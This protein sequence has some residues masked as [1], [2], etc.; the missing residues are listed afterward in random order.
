MLIRAREG[1]TIEP[2]LAVLRLGSRLPDGKTRLA[3]TGSSRTFVA[4]PKYSGYPPNRSPRRP[5][6]RALL[7]TIGIATALIAGVIALEHFHTQGQRVVAQPP[8]TPMRC[9]PGSIVV[10]ESGTNVISEFGSGSVTCYPAA[11]TGDAVPTQSFFKVMSGPDALAFDS[12]GDL[13]VGN[14]ESNKLVEYP[15]AQL[16]KASPV[17]GT[18]ISSDA[19]DSLNEPAGLTFDRSGDLWV[20]N[21][22][23]DTDAEYRRAQ[24]AKVR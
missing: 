3:G 14:F 17:P 22:G 6:R 15:K 20:A 2:V 8:A 12:Y 7:V 16:S 18:V 1:S 5:A 9:G 11:S 13:W 24:L 10:A 21:Q 19:Y 4:H 23:A